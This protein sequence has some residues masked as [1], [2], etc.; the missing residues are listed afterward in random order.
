[1][2]PPGLAAQK[3]GGG[4]HVLK[5]AQRRF[6]EE[7]LGILG[8]EAQNRAFT[9][10]NFYELPGGL[11]FLLSFVD[12][13]EPSHAPGDA[14]GRRRS[15]RHARAAAETAGCRLGRRR[16]RRRARIGMRWPARAGR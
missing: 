8:W 7:A 6:F 4:F 14:F 13:L 10:T 1:M 2:L 16:S 11:D 12:A 5:A 9:T 15:S 3:R